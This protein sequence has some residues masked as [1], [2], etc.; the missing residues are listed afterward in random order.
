M[1][2]SVKSRSS[3]AVCFFFPAQTKHGQV[4]QKCGELP[5]RLQKNRCAR[6]KT[7]HPAQYPQPRSPPC[8]HSMAASLNWV[9]F[10]FLLT[11]FEKPNMFTIELPRFELSTY[12]YIKRFLFRMFL[13]WKGFLAQWKNRFPDVLPLPFLTPVRLGVLIPTR[14]QPGPVSVSCHTPE[15][16]LLSYI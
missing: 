9:V 3:C 12:A 10:K 8:S 4:S 2:S 14:L 1:I 5:G 6:G 15:T 11:S 7:C 16:L 13:L